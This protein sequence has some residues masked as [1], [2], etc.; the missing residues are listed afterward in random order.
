MG[1]CI[2]AIKDAKDETSFAQAQKKAGKVLAL[3]QTE[4]LR[5]KLQSFVATDPAEVMASGDYAGHQ[6]SYSFKGGNV[7]ELLKQLELKFEDDLLAVEKAETNSVNAYNLAKD[8][9]D[10]AIEAAEKARDEKT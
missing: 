7:L 8:A 9:R 5:T 1:E 3:V 2:Q 4:E 10:N 6:K